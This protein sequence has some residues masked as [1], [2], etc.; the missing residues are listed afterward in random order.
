M[1]STLNLR[2]S[3]VK[4]IHMFRIPHLKGIAGVILHILKVPHLLK[5]GGGIP[6]PDRQIMKV[7][8]SEGV[9]AEE[10]F[11][12]ISKLKMNYSYALFWMLRNL[13]LIKR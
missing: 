1:R 7:L 12:N 3:S 13:P 8:G 10:F 2:I 6:H 11:D 4:L 5:K 9:S